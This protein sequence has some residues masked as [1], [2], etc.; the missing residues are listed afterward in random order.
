MS[1]F[2]VWGDSSLD[3]MAPL[4]ENQCRLIVVRH[5]ETEWNAKGISQGWTD[6]PLNDTGREQ[7]RALR[8]KLLGFSMTKAYASSLSRAI[9]TA[10]IILGENGANVIA[11][12]AIRFFRSKKSWLYPFKTKKGQKKEV[13]QEI[14][15]D[16]IAYLRKLSEKHPGENVLVVTHRKVMKQILFALGGKMPKKK[17]VGNAEILRIISE[18]GFLSLET[19]GVSRE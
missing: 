1:F 8:E 6:I 14:K 2:P 18:E 13:D 19:G 16:A 4:K 5:G 11:D 10:E 12:P 17:V 3:K 9:E 15:T 7:A